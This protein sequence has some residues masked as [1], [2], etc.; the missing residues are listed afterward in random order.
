MS[1]ATSIA[2]GTRIDS[3]G[4]CPR[5][6]A[7]AGT[8]AT[9]TLKI[10][11]TDPQDLFADSTITVDMVDANDAPVFTNCPSAPVN[12]FENRA[13]S[14]AVGS[15]IVAT[16]TD[17]TTVGTTTIDDT[18][19]YTVDT[20]GDDDSNPEFTVDAGTGQIRIGACSGCTRLDYETKTSYTVVLT[21]ND[22]VGTNAADK[23]ASSTC[24][25]QVD[26]LDEN[27]APTCDVGIQ[28]DINEHAS[29]GL[30]VGELLGSVTNGVC[31]DEDAGDTALLKYY[32]R[33]SSFKDDSTT[34]FDQLLFA[35][36]VAY[37]ASPG[38]LRNFV[39]S[40]P[41]TGQLQT[42]T[43]ALNFEQLFLLN[44]QTYV[45]LTLVVVDPDGD[46]AVLSVR[47]NIPP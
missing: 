19:T 46:Y 29:P 17:S 32:L 24:V 26:I 33:S 13:P 15:P 12:L 8:S 34:A 47:V 16:D 36:S 43:E 44:D 41:L 22:H 42:T 39:V 40:D 37:D 5:D 10:R 38:P 2:G 30:N 4:V 11:V 1:V 18:V 35:N 9:F 20:L 25:V 7:G 23:G 3:A 31:R 27:E 6:A 45:G 14:S 21:A 28:R